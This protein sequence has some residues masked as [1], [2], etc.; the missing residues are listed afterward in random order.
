MKHILSIFIICKT[1]MKFKILINNIATWNL[2]AE[3]KLYDHYDLQKNAPIQVENIPQ[4][5]ASI[6]IKW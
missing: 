3:L 4:V 1:N 2:T 6:P 5:S